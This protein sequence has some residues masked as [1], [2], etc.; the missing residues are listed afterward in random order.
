[1]RLV[2]PGCCLHNI[3]RDAAC[4]L[5]YLVSPPA[6]PIGYAHCWQLQ[7]RHCGSL[8]SDAVPDWIM[9]TAAAME[10][11]SWQGDR[12]IIQQSLLFL[13]RRGTLSAKGNILLLE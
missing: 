3:N 12:A 8:P 4:A 2:A 9:G 13:A 6:F 7:C 10:S 1:M 5:S 11:S